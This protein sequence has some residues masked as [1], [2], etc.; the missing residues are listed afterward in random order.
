[1][2]HAQNAAKHRERSGEKDQRIKILGS[3]SVWQQEFDG[4]EEYGQAGLRALSEYVVRG[5]TEE[6]HQ[7]D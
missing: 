5:E 2:P 7:A 6:A 3:G 4:A 1:M